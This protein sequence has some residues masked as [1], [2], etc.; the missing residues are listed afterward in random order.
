MSSAEGATWAG[1]GGLHTRKRHVPT[2]RGVWIRKCPSA[3]QRWRKNTRF[4]LSIYY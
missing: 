3:L 2:Y 1:A 4:T